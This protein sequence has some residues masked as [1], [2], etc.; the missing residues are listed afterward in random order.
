[1]GIANIND[2]NIL[3]RN[4][5]LKI[6]EYMNDNVEYTI[7]IER[8]IKEIPTTLSKRLSIFEY[9]LSERVLFRFSS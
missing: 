4:L 3:V 2:I 7:Y 5:L 8:S 1:M 9:E 6:R